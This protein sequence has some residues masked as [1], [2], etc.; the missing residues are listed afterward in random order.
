MV[1]NV[2]LADKPREI[3][4]VTLTSVLLFEWVDMP[5][6]YGWACLVFHSI[7]GCISNTTFNQST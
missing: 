3:T 2:L 1:E 6:M 7:G 5:M 4:L